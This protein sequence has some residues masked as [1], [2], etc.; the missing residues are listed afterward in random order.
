MIESGASEA[1]AIPVRLA[2]IV[3]LILS[4]PAALAVQVVS[5]DTDRHSAGLAIF[6]YAD[7]RFIA[8]NEHLPSAARNNV[9]GSGVVTLQ[10]KEDRV[11]WPVA[12]TIRRHPTSIRISLLRG[13]GSIGGPMTIGQR[14]AI[15]AALRETN[16]I[17]LVD[18][19]DRRTPT[20][21]QRW[22]G[23]TVNLVAGWFVAAYGVYILQ[24]LTARVREWRG[25]A[26]AWEGLCPSCGYD[27][28]GNPAGGRC[29]ECGA[30]LP[31]RAQFWASRKSRDRKPPTAQ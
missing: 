4:L 27:L 31:E 8:T 22:W 11:G 18:A 29:T 7:G 15:V 14:Q 6:E 3:G 10:T 20:V 9:V 12:A 23:W 13:G 24:H 30:D 25:K 16:D 17:A 21:E 1:K 2:I 28:S 19:I 5:R 26:R